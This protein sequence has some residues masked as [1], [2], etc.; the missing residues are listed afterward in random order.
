MIRQFKG[1]SH[2]VNAVAFSPDGRHIISGGGQG[3]DSKD[4][5]LKLWDMAT[6]ELIRTFSGHT[7]EINA[8][9]F[10]PDGQYAIS[11]SS[12]DTVKLWEIST[13]KEIRTF[14]E[15]NGECVAFS[16]DGQYVLAPR[17][18]ELK[19]FE[20]S[21]GRQVKVFKKKHSGI[22]YSVDFSPDGKFAVSADSDGILKLWEVATGREL[23]SFHGHSASVNSVVFAPDGQ[24][25]L[26]GSSDNTL[27]L[28]EVATGNKL[29]TYSGKKIAISAVAFSPDGRYV[30]SDFGR[31]LSLWDVVAGKQHQ[32]FK[33]HNDGV[34][35]VAFSPDG[36]YALSGAGDFNGIADNTLK[37]WEIPSGRQLR[38][39]EGHTNGVTCLAFS[40]DGQNILS[41]SFDDTLKLWKVATGQEIWTI[42]GKPY[43]SSF[44][45]A[46]SK[47]GRLALATQ[48]DLRDAFDPKSNLKLYNVKT[49]REISSLLLEGTGEIAFSPDRKYVLTYMF[50]L[51]TVTWQ[52]RIRKVRTYSERHPGYVSSLAFSPDA[53]YFLSGGHDYKLMLWEVASGN[54]LMTFAGHSGHAT[55]VAFSPDNRYAL[56]GSRDGTL[57]LWNPDTG[58]EIVQ[59]IAFKDGEWIVTTPD[60]YYNSSAAG[61][62]HLN[63]RIGNKVYGIDQYRNTFYKP[64]VVEAALRLGNTQQAIAEVLGSAKQ[65]STLT[66]IK[67]IEPPFIVIKSPEDGERLHSASAAVSLYVE[68]RNRPLQWIKVYIN[69]RQVTGKDARG[70]QIA[71]KS[72][73]TPLGPSGIK[74]PEGKKRLDIKIPA[75][76]ERG[77]NLIEVVAFNGYSQ[78]RRSIRAQ[79]L[80]QGPQDKETSILPNLW[81]LSIGINNYQDKKIPSLSYAVADAHGIVGAFEKQKG[82]LFREVNSL[83]ISDASPTKP[84]TENIIDN[85]E[86][87]GQAGHRDVVLLFIAG[88]GINDNRGDFYF[89]PN[90]A[91]FTPDGRIKKSK[92]ILWSL[93]NQTLDLPAKKL[94]FVDTCHSEGLGG[95]QT[96]TRA[97]D[98]DRFVKELQEANAVIFTSSRGS[99]LSQE[100]PKWGHG[101][102]TFALL[103][104]LSGKADLIK[105]S[106]ISMKELDTYVSETVPRMT[107]GAQHPIT[108]TPDGYINFP[109][110]LIK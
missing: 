103:E 61:D 56:S 72:G 70:V 101:A 8:V 57:R 97:V 99:E 23:R 17:Y 35:Q 32:S 93:L 79:L 104:G 48:Q 38:S 78:G 92:A 21:S 81:I 12:D 58:K 47:D 7:K 54:R 75:V 76:L 108:N 109:V 49:G 84:S 14:P 88:H 71:K 41:G 5:T 13:G 64:Q 67:T 86:Y 19:L 74:I 46:F 15:V 83:I 77:E 91:A 62:K 16:P 100:D 30:L 52:K 34:N 80:A 29:A 18:R 90:D 20:V 96:K 69:G 50:N 10:S 6:G 2:E 36:Q 94:I 25:V 43:G 105:D 65:K 102:F 1:H 44:N 95:K 22:V 37:L 26:S 89:L 68:D 98:N 40:P 107:N 28:W 39:F 82:V 66:E 27:K 11:A 55:A 24:Y 3:I 31:D 73:L 110:T 59:M 63:V 9:A 53:R 87:L 85:L 60:G 4:A 45:V 42:S 33:G 106:K 51:L